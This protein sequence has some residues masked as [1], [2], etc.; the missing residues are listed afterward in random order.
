VIY[1]SIILPT[2]NRAS[3]INK[4]VESVLNQTFKGFELII[5]DDASTDD[6][7]QKVRA[8][9]D[10]RIIYLKNEVNLERCK[11]RNKGIMAARGKYICFLDSDDYHLPE[12]LETL[13]AEIQRR[14]E[15]EALFF[16]NAWD[17]KD[18]ERVERN[19]PD[20]E[21]HN[22]FHYIVSYTFNPQRMCVHSNI[23][24]E[25]LFDPAV[26][27]CEDLDF[28]ARI[29]TKYPVVQIKKRTTVY[30]HHPNS[31]TGGDK[32]KALKELENY[33]RIFNR[34]ELKR[35]IPGRSK[36]RIIS[37]CHFHLAHYWSEK[38]QYLKL[39]KSIVASFFLCPLGYNRKTNKILLYLSLK[40]FYK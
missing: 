3:F 33:T 18:G 4:A 2:Y 6:T 14:N 34:K 39:Y 16:T 24:K 38:R 13:Y 23:C 9:D 40:H 25:F 19:C 17:E 10:K 11:S 28:S 8:Y 35:R 12:H 32:Q 30:V 31:F 22:L 37:M 36:R 7:E 26:Y 1:F 21:C 27:I 29:A 20:V 15:P 5:V